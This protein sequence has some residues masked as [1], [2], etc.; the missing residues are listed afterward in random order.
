MAMRAAKPNVATPS[1][2]NGGQKTNENHNTDAPASNGSQGRDATHGASAP[3]SNGHAKVDSVT[4]SCARARKNGTATSIARPNLETPFLQLT[5][6]CEVWEDTMELRRGVQARVT[7]MLKEE[8]GVPEP[9]MLMLAALEEAEKHPKKMIERAAK[10]HPLYPWQQEVHGLGV[11]SFGVLMAYLNGSAVIAS[12]KRRV[13]NELVEEEP[14]VRTVS[15]LWSYCG[16][17]DSERRRVKNMTQDELL[18][19][20][21]PKLKARLRLIAEAFLKA[22][23]RDVYDQARAK[24]EHAVH[25]IPCRGRGRCGLDE[26]TPWRD[27]HKHAAALR[28]VA[29]EFLRDLYDAESELLGA[30]LPTTPMDVSPRVARPKTGVTD[31]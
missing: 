11:H 9:L 20:G 17:G 5:A 27:G 30:R 8:T 7:R 16:Y 28:A 13:G 24:Y 22:G 21:K 10:L 14:Y 18:A 4:R 29:K 26:G 19:M 3:A 6:A 15:Q 12:P 2:S 25:A 1:Q 23:N 31:A